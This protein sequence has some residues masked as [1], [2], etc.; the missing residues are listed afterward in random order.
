SCESKLRRGRLTT[1]WLAQGYSLDESDNPGW[2]FNKLHETT[3]T[4]RRPSRFALLVL[5]SQP[6][7]RDPE[8]L[9]H[10]ERARSKS[11]VGRQEVDGEARIL[12]LTCDGGDHVDADRAKQSD[13]STHVYRGRHEHDVF[14]VEWR[15]HGL[16]QDG[17]IAGV[18]R[19]ALH[20]N[21]ICG[22]AELD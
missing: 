4:V 18:E 13:G 2:G 17:F 11:G 15:E 1:E 7:V 10:G 9:M 12:A 6:V 3:I 5:A 14:Y 16:N 21:A 20:E 19:F 22:N 8:D